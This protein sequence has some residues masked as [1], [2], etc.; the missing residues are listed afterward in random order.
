MN[1]YSLAGINV[2]AEEFLR[3]F[4]ALEDKVCLRVFADKKGSAFS[5]QNLEC[6]L[7]DFGTITE[8]LRK[9]NEHERGVYFVINHGGQTDEEISRIN[10]QY[11]EC[12][13]LTLEEQLV[14]IQ[15]FPLEPSLIV[16]T[17]NSLHCYWL[18]KNA[19]KEKFRHIQKR[20]ITHFDADPACI[21]ESRVF[22]LPGFYHCKE[23]P[24]LVECIKFNPE[25]RYTQEQ[26]ESVLPELPDEAAPADVASAPSSAMRGRGT[27]KGLVVAGKRCAFLQHCKKNA[28]TLSE[29]DWYAMITNLAVFEGGEDAIHALSKPYPKYTYEATQKKID[30]YYK[31]GTKPMTCQR[32]SEQ[33]FKCP[34]KNSCKCKSPAGLAFIPLPL[35][36]LKKL[37]IKLKKA[38]DPATDIQTAHK[39]VS[40][41]LFNQDASIAEAV[42]RHDLKDYFGFKADDVR[43]L[44]AAYK[45]MSG[46]LNEARNTQR[47]GEES[48]K[49]YRFNKSGDL[50]LMP[51][52]LAGHLAENFHAFYCTEQYYFYSNGVY[53]PKTEKDAKAVVQEYL[54]PTEMTANHINDAEFQWQLKIRKPIIEINPNPYII[55]CTNGLYN[56]LD[57]S[58]RPHDPKYFSTVQLKT[59]YDPEAKCPRW[60][61]FLHSSLD[62]PE[63]HLLQEIFG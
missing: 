49:Y 17:R 34:R 3:P 2:P 50:Q 38:N 31:S 6:T 27:Q 29:P 59:R 21:N 24:V 56:V 20:L 61:E 33:G 58:F 35:T 47:S 8:S 36:D 52:V 37:V 39:Y 30:H 15:A 22:R 7:E 55:N 57:D 26:L 11:M 28:K 46:K 5:G 12:D 18:M 44:I 42:I 19:K 60:M 48:P 10:A 51:G 40:D 4:F 43:P 25:L 14:K 16:K 54:I 41:Y 45:E 32:I 53:T 63:I 9:H 23:E 13:K 1:N 62:E